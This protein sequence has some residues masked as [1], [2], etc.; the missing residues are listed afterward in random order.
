MHLWI[1]DDKQGRCVDEN[2][3]VMD[4]LIYYYAKEQ[5]SIAY[6]YREL[7]LDNGGFTSIRNDM[8]LDRDRVKEIQETID[9]DYTIPLDF[10]FLPGI[11]QVEMQKLWKKTAD[12]IQDWQETTNLKALVPMLHAWSVESLVSN[13]R[14]LQKHANAHCIAVGSVVSSDYSEYTGFL[15]DRQ[16]RKELVDMLVSTIQVIRH[17]SDFKIHLAGFGC[18][19]LML[20]IGYFCGVD[21]TDTIG[22]KRKAAFGKISLPGLGDRHIGRKP[23]GW[24]TRK[25]KPEEMELLRTCGCPICRRNPRMLWK[26]WMA[27]AIHNKYVLLEERKKA[28]QYMEKGRDVYEAF[29]DEMF[30]KSG[31]KYLWRYAKTRVHYY[32]LNL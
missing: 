23:S 15:G 30:A 32:P 3:S 7:F 24:G 9:P 29:L 21:S 19:A 13:T 6:E 28:R 27:R 18:S 16:P 2:D 14:W 20:H 26:E 1:G 17:F 5:P 10:P 22:Y 31:L 12:N 11:S 4:S 25:L 8:K